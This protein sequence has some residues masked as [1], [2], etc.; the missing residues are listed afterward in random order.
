MTFNLW[1]QTAFSSY[2]VLPISRYTC[3]NWYLTFIGNRFGI[4]IQ[5]AW[6]F[7]NVMCSWIVLT[8]L[9]LNCWRL[10]LCFI[11]KDCNWSLN[12]H[13]SIFPQNVWSISLFV[14]VVTYKLYDPTFPFIWQ[15]CIKF[16]WIKIPSY[17]PIN[18][19]Y[20]VTQT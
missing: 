5:F 1:L 16:L 6:N 18:W 3:I 11:G 2:H 15:S 14:K 13:I 7:T 12:M 20:L 19:C 4:I 8:I 17:L 9:M 10:Y